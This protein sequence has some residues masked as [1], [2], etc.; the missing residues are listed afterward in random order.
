[1]PAPILAIAVVGAL[2]AS[3]ENTIIA[4]VVVWWPLYARI[5][6]GEARAFLARPAADAARLMR[7]GRIRFAVRHLLP[8]MVPP[9]RHCRNVRYWSANSDAG[10]S[11]VSRAG[12]ALASAPNWAQ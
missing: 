10:R 6:R 12:F 5:V 8:G 11:L 3:L 2:G 7:I 4:M 1:M 9:H